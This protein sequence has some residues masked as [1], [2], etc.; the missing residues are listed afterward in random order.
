M[1]ARIEIDT[2]QNIWA[3]YGAKSSRSISVWLGCLLLE[4]S[5]G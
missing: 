4:V 5:L 1:I 3:W 2:S